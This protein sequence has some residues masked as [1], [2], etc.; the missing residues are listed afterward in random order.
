MHLA[1]IQGA[2]HAAKQ[3]QASCASE[4]TKV[5]RDENQIT[6]RLATLPRLLPLKVAAEELGLPVWTLR[7][8]IWDGALAAVHVGRVVRIDRN[9]LEAWLARQKTRGP[10]I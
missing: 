4:E 1:S 2:R 8:A 10:V 6:A 3:P 9:D 7:R 5:M